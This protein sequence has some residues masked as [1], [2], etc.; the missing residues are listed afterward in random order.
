[1]AFALRQ[2]FFVLKSTLPL[3]YRIQIDGLESLKEKI[4]H[5]SRGILF[6]PNHP[7]EIDPVMIMT[8][9]WDQFH[10]RP[11][12]IEHFFYTWCTHYLRLVKALSV[13]S[14]VASGNKWKLAQVEKLI[15][16]VEIGL[17]NKEN[18]LIYPAGRLKEEGE[19]L[20]GGASL[21][22]KILNLSPDTNVVLVR[23]TGL[24]GS[25]FSRALTGKIP[26][27]GDVFK[28]GLKLVLRNGIFFAPKR[29]VHI[30][31]E[32]APEDFPYRASRQELNHYLEKWY[33]RYP[34]EGPEPLNLVS[35]VF[36]RQEYPKIEMHS[37]STTLSDEPCP[38]EVERE[39]FKYLALVS[40]RPLEEI[41]RYQHLS[42]DLG[43]DSLD[44]ANLSCFVSIYAQGE[45]KTVDDLC[46]AAL[47]KK[48]EE[49]QS[50]VDR[51]AWNRLPFVEMLRK[52]PRAPVGNT[53]PTAFLH[54]CNRMGYT[55]ACIDKQ[56]GTLNYIDLKREAL[57]LSFRIKEIPGN[58]VGILLPASVSVNLVSV[59][60]MLAGKTPVLLDW[61]APKINDEIK[62]IISSYLFLGTIDVND[63]QSIEEFL[64]FV[65]DF[66]SWK[67]RVRAFLLTTVGTKRISKKFNLQTDAEQTAVIVN[68][69]ALS[70]KNILNEQ[71]VAFESIPFK[72]EDIIYNGMPPFRSF[73]TSLMP[74]LSCLKVCY[75]QE[76]TP[77]SSK[78][79][80]SDLDEEGKTVY[81]LLDAKTNS[82]KTL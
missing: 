77:I 20:I 30:H 33:N 54:A 11:L 82:I 14:M 5:P 12:V 25:R 56:L 62:V 57:F 4:K 46:K 7:A 55:T 6:L 72:K 10:L 19:E 80:I 17:K 52:K 58:K 78:L 51:Q 74:I 66:R 28:E 75:G 34:N 22:H 47:G 61:K 45:L 50:A 63:L 64:L 81:R 71:R 27:L 36:W 53:I 31:F 18:F 3:R 42:F 69:T 15:K 70:H 24:W 1:M 8:L 59:A 13:P 9:L 29:K 2:V 68:E 76:P 73:G 26:N 39:I 67:N 44:V 41:H 21:V 38:K 79:F 23:I 49:Q 32:E 37:D 40:K 43:L 65:E 16:K 48:L 60:C 35:N